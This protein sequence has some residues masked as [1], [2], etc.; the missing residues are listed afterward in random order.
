MKKVFG[1]ETSHIGYPAQPDSFRRNKLVSTEK[2]QPCG[3]F[4]G[5]GGPRDDLDRF[6]VHSIPKETMKKVL[7]KHLMHK[8]IIR[9]E[10]VLLQT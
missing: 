9:V 10:Y 5:P 1:I 7:E 2:N 3:V 4:A 6:Q 8:E